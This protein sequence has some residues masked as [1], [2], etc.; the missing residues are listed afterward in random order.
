MPEP[1]YAELVKQ[2]I[3]RLKVMIAE[4][5]SQLLDVEMEEDEELS[6]QLS[7]SV[8]EDIFA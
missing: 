2:Q 6:A 3:A 7:A 1:T 8:N 5:Q 4:L